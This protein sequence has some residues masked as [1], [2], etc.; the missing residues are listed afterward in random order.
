[1]KK[2]AVTG[3]VVSLT[4]ENF[5]Q[6]PNTNALQLLNGRASGVSISQTSSAP[7]APT[8]IQ[9][10]GAGS[11]NS[12]NK[13]LV[14]VDGLPGVDP[15]SIS[16]DDIKSIEILKDA[17][18]AAIYGTRAANGVVLI[19]TK[20]GKK[21]DMLVNFSAGYG[22]QS[23]AKKIDVLDGRQY[24][25]TLNAIRSDAGQPLI[26]TQ[27]QI[28]SIGTGT[29]WQNEVFNQ[30]APVQ[31]YQ[32]SISGGGDKHDYYAGL[33]YYNQDGLVQHS[34]F[35]KLNF[36][37][38]FN[39]NAKE[40][41]RFKLN[42]NFTRGIQNSILVTDGVNEG[43]GPINAAI[44]FDPTLPVGLDAAGKYYANSFIALDNPLA[45]L[46]GISNET[47]SNNLY[48]TFTTEIEPVKGLVGT[49]RLGGALSSS[50]GSFYRD[51][52]TLNGLAS[53]G[54]GSKSGTDN[55][56]WLAEFLLKYDKKW[57]RNH[58]LSLLAGTT[59][60]EFLYQGLGAS[61]IRFLSDVTGA[62]LL[63][64]G[65]NDQ[66]DN[67][68]SFKDRNR[69]NG[70]IGRINY[71]YKDRYLLT[72]SF[73][74]DG[75]SRFSDAQKF[76]FFPSGALAW[77]VSKE[78]FFNSL[79]PMVTDFKWRISYGELGNQG[80]GNYQT[81]QTLVAGGAAIFGNSI[82]QGVV[83]A[84]IP[85]RNLRWETTQEF[86]TGIDFSLWNNRI[87]GSVDYYIRNT[88]D[89]LFSKPLPSV[90][91][92]T[93]IMI[94]AGA[95]RNTGWDIQ[96][97]SVNIDKAA[98]SWS[99]SF[100]MSFLKNEV[101]SL[102]PSIPQIITGSTGGFISNYQIVA[103]GSPM[104]SFYGYQADGIFRSADEVAL[105]SQPTAKPGHIRF[106]DQNKDGK[107]D[108]TDRVILGDP[109]P[110]FTAGL[111]NRFVYKRFS[112]DL[113]FQLV[114]G[115][116]TLDAN[117]LESFYPTNEYRNRIA[118]YYEDRWTPQNPDAAYPSGVN[119][120]AYGGAFSINS[121]TILDASFLRFK[122]ANLSYSVPLSSSKTFRAIQVYLAADNI[123]TITNYEGFDP[124][125]SNTG[126]EAISKV[127]YNSYPLN[128]TIRMG[129]NLQF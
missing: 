112:L 39:F 96:L 77:R 36:R 53:R 12:S 1:Q 98:F 50:M 57:G 74:N 27:R 66:G 97:N 120:S 21:G 92:F 8:K 15:T 82:L 91:G 28:D 45:L 46:N 104:Q 80:I 110:D 124:D 17:S 115:I 101:T 127:N 9:I 26:F 79:L 20:S 125:A 81:L 62:D 122:T 114:S 52:S 63:Q 83:P 84:R 75:T 37:T 76:A 119:P 90:V 58:S 5:T 113:F 89:Q 55:A 16:P 49:I 71:G 54:A 23:V 68:S 48:G 29:N 126:S 47:L 40:F 35:K 33:N 32:L 117:V 3:A 67:V 59:F 73:R 44:Q 123:V 10:R 102:P 4:S 129:I 100:N 42:M 34:N 6:G 14:V 118:R 93:S 41:L 61:S 60:E 105:S 7:G 38:N 30:A 24:M 72:A 128:R 87:S 18:S 43:A 65:D 31:N 103:V 25:E 51:R 109:F 2:T 99:S 95:V 85:N 88:R 56:Q 11:I 107:I 64:S 116:Q 86:N 13:A 111:N 69:L 78:P 121:F 108:A 22:I 19:T 106:R 70:I 94:N